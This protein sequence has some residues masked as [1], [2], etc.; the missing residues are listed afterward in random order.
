MATASRSRTISADPSAIW[1]VLA[2]FGALSRWADGIDHSCL[3]RRRDD[4]IGTSRRVQVGRDTLVETIAVFD[5]PRELA[6]DIEG[7]PQWFSVSN[8]WN[9]RSHAGSPTTVTLTSVVQMR[10]NPLRPIAERVFAGL[11]ARR[12]DELLNS[13]AKHLERTR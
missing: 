13:L 5:A 12:S 2:D 11:M 7:L 1:D 4:P 3:L 10:P 8:Q 9:I 6:Y